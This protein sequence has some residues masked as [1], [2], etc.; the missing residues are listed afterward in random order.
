MKVLST[1]VGETAADFL[2]Y[3][4]ISKTDVNATPA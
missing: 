1:T 3:L 2:R 4:A